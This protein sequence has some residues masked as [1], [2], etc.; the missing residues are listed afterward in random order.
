MAF[1]LSCLIHSLSCLV[2]LGRSSLKYWFYDGLPPWIKDKLSKG[3]GKH[4]PVEDLQ[5][6]AQRIN[7]HYWERVQE[8]SCKKRSTQKPNPPKTNPPTTSSSVPTSSQPWSSNPKSNKPKEPTKPTTPK[9]NL[10]GKLD[11]HGKLTQQEWQRQIDKNLCMFCG[12]TDH[13]LWFLYFLYFLSLS[14][15]AHPWLCIAA[16][17]H[18]LVVAFI[19]LIHWGCTLQSASL[20][21]T[22]YITKQPSLYVYKLICLVV[23]P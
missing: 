19:L 15:I 11:S 16:A 18:A 23:I 10:T 22:C 12:G 2:S 7:S 8:C 14:S 9:V 21:P 1:Q 17:M 20:L 4:Q 5:N 6:A 13:L 3:Q